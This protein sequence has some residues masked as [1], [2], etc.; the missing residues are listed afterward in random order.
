MNR[1]LRYGLAAAAFAALSAGA[2]LAEPPRPHHGGMGGM[3]S[4]DCAMMGAAENVPREIL[5]YREAL[6]LSDDQVRELYALAETIEQSQ[7]RANELLTPAQRDGLF[8]A[9]RH[10]RMD[11]PM[12]EGHGRRAQ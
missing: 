6:E 10:R 7:A 4:G 2:A 9:E 1:H 12:M 11:C 8:Q 3:M 5:I